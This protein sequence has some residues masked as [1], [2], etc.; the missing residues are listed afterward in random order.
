MPRKSYGDFNDDSD[1]FRR[2]DP[3]DEDLSY[4]Y[5][6]LIRFGLVWGQ[7]DFSEGIDYIFGIDEL[8]NKMVT[9]QY[10]TWKVLR[11]IIIEFIFQLH[12]CDDFIYKRMF[13]NAFYRP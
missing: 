7:P 3:L 2:N 8:K 13:Q 1:D 11:N 12:S 6:N 9:V 5:Y 10:F 4:N